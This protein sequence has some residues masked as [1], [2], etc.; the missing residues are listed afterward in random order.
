MYA[1]RSV[2]LNDKIVS[3]ITQTKSFIDQ[4]L[5]HLLLKHP[6]S[7]QNALFFIPHTTEY[8]SQY[9]NKLANIS[10]CTMN[11]N[12]R[13][14]LVVGFHYGLSSLLM[15]H[16]QPNLHITCIDTHKQINTTQW[17]SYQTIQTHFVNRIQF[18]VGE[19]MSVLLS[20]L[21][22]DYDLVYLDTALAVANVDS[23]T[24]T[25][26]LKPHGIVF[27]ANKET[28]P[29]PDTLSACLISPT[30]PIFTMDNHSVWKYH[31]TI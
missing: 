26:L 9:I 16:S 23:F 4:Y 10:I 5:S 17:N 22:G 20:S 14:V 1:F 31:R 7:I 19:N 6:L 13:K 12:V 29:I 2:I 18:F 8:T 15:L 25:P 28:N 21:S 3:K 30:I 11:E 24:W 27:M